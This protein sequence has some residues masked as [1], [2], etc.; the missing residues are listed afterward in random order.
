MNERESKAL[1]KHLVGIKALTDDINA[2]TARLDGRGRNP[3]RLGDAIREL[4]RTMAKHGRTRMLLHVVSA[5]TR[6]VYE[7]HLLKKIDRKR[8][9]AS[10]RLERFYHGGANTIEVEAFGPEQAA[11]TAAG[12][13]Q[14]AEKK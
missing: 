7:I 11:P 1:A 10:R 3:D 12:S 4:A 14:M 13:R 2:T 5:D 6:A 9:A 8:G